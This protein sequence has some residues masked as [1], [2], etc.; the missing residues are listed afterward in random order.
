MALK[1]IKHSN[2]IQKLKAYLGEEGKMENVARESQESQERAELH[3]KIWAIADSE[4]VR[5]L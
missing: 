3:K 2:I 1:K 5:E 4:K